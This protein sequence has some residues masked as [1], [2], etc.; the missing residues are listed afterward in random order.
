MCEGICNQTY[1]DCVDRC[2]ENE[3]YTKCAAN[4]ES[5][6]KACPCNDDCPDGCEF[7]NNQACACSVSTTSPTKNLNGKLGLSIL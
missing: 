5:C 1:I 6:L 7:C 2:G 3:C 4:R